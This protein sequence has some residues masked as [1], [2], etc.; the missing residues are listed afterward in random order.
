MIEKKHTWIS[1]KGP[2]NMISS[3]G[4]KTGHGSGSGSYVGNCRADGAMFNISLGRETG[5]GAGKASHGYSN[6]LGNGIG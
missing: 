3:H 2:P 6:R 5:D 4:A 1:P